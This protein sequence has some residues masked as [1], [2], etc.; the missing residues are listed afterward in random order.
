MLFKSL[1]GIWI[2]ADPFK[3]K[4]LPLLEQKSA[5]SAN[6]ACR[7]WEGT[8]RNCHGTKYGIICCKT[9]GEWKTFYVHRLSFMFHHSL[10]MSELCELVGEVS[11]L[12]HN[13]LCI[14]PEHLHLEPSYHNRYRAACISRGVCYTHPGH[15][16]CLLH[17]KL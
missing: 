1:E 8:I 11:H 7:L 17:L 5:I 4:Y 12:C 3:E 9:G 10:S 16:E 13:S 2:M 6:N 14:T 15:P